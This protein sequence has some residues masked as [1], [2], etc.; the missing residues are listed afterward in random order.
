MGT[1]RGSGYYTIPYLD[2][3]MWRETENPKL[4]EFSE[5]GE[6]ALHSDLHCQGDVGGQGRP[7]QEAAGP[8][9]RALQHQEVH[10][11]EV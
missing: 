10:Q 3:G 9:Q 11:E 2:S 7:L 5:N 6:G 4:F 1:N 8:G